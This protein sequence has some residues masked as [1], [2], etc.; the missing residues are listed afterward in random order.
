M[1]GED[2]L[3]GEREAEIFGCAG[4]EQGA[5]GRNVSL[6]AQHNNMGTLLAQFHDA[7]AGHLD[8]DV[9]D[10]GDYDLGRR[11]AGCLA[12]RAA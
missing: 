4:F 3:G 12:C 8:G 11:N 10:F 2:V 1:R 6:F 9:A 7:F 5:I